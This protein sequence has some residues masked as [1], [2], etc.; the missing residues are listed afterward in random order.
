MVGLMQ[1][2]ILQR[3][4]LI[5]GEK[6]TSVDMSRLSSAQKARF[7]SWLR[8]NNLSLAE[9]TEQAFKKPTK[10]NVMEPF[11]QSIKGSNN[12]I[13]IDIQFIPEFFPTISRDLKS[14]QTISQIFSQSEIAYSETKQ[15]PSATLVGIFAAKEALIKAGLQDFDKDNLRT[16]EICHDESGAP[17]FSGYN[18]SISHSN[19]YAISV[20]IKKNQNID[21]EKNKLSISKKST[22]DFEPS[23][24]QVKYAH[25]T[26]KGFS[27]ISTIFLVITL[28]IVVSNIQYFIVWIE[29]LIEKTIV[30]I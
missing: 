18:L 3:F 20:A 24:N 23:S 8:E 12:S 1:N 29:Y 11:Y 27:K 17:E 2:D 21:T 6:S 15:N 26:E 14:D 30:N 10:I 25:T 16:I 19:D 9:T 4:N 22:D 28:S 13:G 7:I 5:L